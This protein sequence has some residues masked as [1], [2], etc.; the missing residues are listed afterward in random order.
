M[1][2]LKK[3]LPVLVL[4]AVATAGSARA[5]QEATVVT[6]G[7]AS[8]GSH[9]A[10]L[11]SFASQYMPAETQG[12]TSDQLSAQEKTEITKRILALQLYHNALAVE[13]S[14]GRPISDKNLIFRGEKLYLPPQGVIDQI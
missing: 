1:K 2:S 7:D 5:A 11:W 9:N 12:K 14:Q 4:V 10:T 8:K 3:M 6:V 13:K